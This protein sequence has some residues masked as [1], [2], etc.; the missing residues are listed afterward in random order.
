MESI[1]ANPSLSV[2]IPCEQGTLNNVKRGRKIL[3]TSHLLI[4]DTI[5]TFLTFYNIFIVFVK[6]GDLV[7]ASC[8]D[9]SLQLDVI[10]IMEILNAQKSVTKIISPAFVNLVTPK[11][12]AKHEHL[13][14]KPASGERSVQI[15]S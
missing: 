14:N 9:S 7:G 6:Q 10:G 4:L 13:F 12:G 3:S 2:S 8:T 11:A 15:I 1:S 5:V